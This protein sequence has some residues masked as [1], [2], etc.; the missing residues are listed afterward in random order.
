MRD[1]CCQAVSCKLGYSS[2]RAETICSS[3]GR[4]R[5]QGRSSTQGHHRDA[6]TG[7]DPHTDRAPAKHA[8]TTP[9]GE[10][11][12]AVR[13]ARDESS[14]GDAPRSPAQGCRAC[15][16]ATRRGRAPDAAATRTS[17]RR[18]A[19]AR[20]STT[21]NA[22]APAASLPP[23]PAAMRHRCPAARACATCS[24][25]LPASLPVLPASLPV[26]P[27]ALN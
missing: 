10:W 23:R 22:R 17:P 1:N 12:A 11:K 7:T 8:C 24:A 16:A 15:L 26:R 2:Y 20:A 25:Q 13:C 5:L 3:A 14:I 6:S 27:V 21:T 4:K 18:A 19:C 9:R